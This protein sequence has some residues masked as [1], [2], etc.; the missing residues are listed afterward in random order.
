MHFNPT[1]VGCNNKFVWLELKLPDRVKDMLRTVCYSVQG[2]PDVSQVQ[3]KW[4]S[5]HM[6]VRKYG[7][8]TEARQVYTSLKRGTCKRWFPVQFSSVSLWHRGQRDEVLDTSTTGAAVAVETPG[9]K[10]KVQLPTVEQKEQV[11]VPPKPLLGFLCAVCDVRSNSASQHQQHVAGAKH[12]A[13][14]QTETA[15]FQAWLAVLA[16][17]VLESSTTAV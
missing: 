5:P 16:E 13:Q 9:A 8:A 4:N 11:C 7:P 6:T 14:L 15:Q 10:A 3:W 12:R 2:M 1:H 17:T